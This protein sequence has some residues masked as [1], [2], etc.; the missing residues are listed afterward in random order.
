MR[1][2]LLRSALLLL[3]ALAT[4]EMTG[5]RVC[6]SAIPRVNLSLPEPE[7]VA[8]LAGAAA[9]HGFYYLVGHGIEQATLDHALRLCGEFF[10]LP[11][12]VKRAIKRADTLSAR[13][14]AERIAGFS[15]MEADRI[16]G[17]PDAEL[18]RGLE[19]RLRPPSEVRAEFTARHRELLSQLSG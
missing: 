1:G 18:I 12:A 19:I 13:L 16:F 17:R 11:V 8:A 4:G 14:E 2:G 15:A 7:L 3:F 10:A 6:T 9:G 5:E